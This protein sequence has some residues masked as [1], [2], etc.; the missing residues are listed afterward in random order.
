MAGDDMDRRNGP[1][2]E[3]YSHDE[4]ENA[5]RLG[6]EQAASGGKLSEALGH[7]ERSL[8]ELGT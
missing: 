3:H 6:A 5:L 7:R 2:C 8:N 1:A 4:L